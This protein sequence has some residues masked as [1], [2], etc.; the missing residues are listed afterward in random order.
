MTNCRR[1]RPGFPSRSR[2]RVPE[3]RGEPGQGR[4]PRRS[5]R[6]GYFWLRFHRLFAG[7]TIQRRVCRHSPTTRL[8]EQAGGGGAEDVHVTVTVYIGGVS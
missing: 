1:S 2:Y 8:P 6:R 5:R 4:H 3:E 7:S